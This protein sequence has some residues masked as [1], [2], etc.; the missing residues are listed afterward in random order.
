MT[1]LG[2]FILICGLLYIACGAR[3]ESEEPS[4]VDLTLPAK[5]FVTMLSQ[6]DYGGCFDRF[7]QTMKDGLPEPKL[8]E[9]WY[10]ILNQVGNFKKQTGVRQTKEGGYDVV[11]V[12]CQFERSKINVKVVFNAHKEVTGLWFRPTQ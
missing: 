5:E 4:A 7:D 1:K 9:A 11:Y 10:T 6:E 2:I 3:E 12:T 8:K